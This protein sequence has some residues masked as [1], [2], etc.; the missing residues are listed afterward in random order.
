MSSTKKYW[1]SSVHSNTSISHGRDYAIDQIRTGDSEDEAISRFAHWSHGYK[2]YRAVA[3][4]PSLLGSG[5]L[6]ARGASLRGTPEGSPRVGDGIRGRYV[7]GD[8]WVTSHLHVIDAET[9][10]ADIERN[11]HLL[12]HHPQ[13]HT[14]LREHAN[15]FLSSPTTE[16]WMH[17]VGHQI[18]QREMFAAVAAR[19]LSRLM[20]I[21]VY[22]PAHNIT[23]PAAVVHSA[24]AYVLTETLE[25]DDGTFHPDGVSHTL[26]D[27]GRIP[28]AAL[29]SHGGSMAPAVAGTMHL[30]N[31]G[32]GTLKVVE[33]GGSNVLAAGQHTEIV[34]DGR[35]SPLVL[36]WTPDPPADDAGTEPAP[37]PEEGA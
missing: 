26:P 1:A 24:G 37:E 22:D 14:V 25:R 7:N 12:G 20:E 23:G 4:V 35:G 10:W 18:E 6:M 19:D 8:Y 27:M 15:P 33:V 32:G 16:R 2:E 30:F 5:A 29:G 34:L 31:F 9:F 21:D 28:L 11:V 17:E 3:P 13:H 36:A